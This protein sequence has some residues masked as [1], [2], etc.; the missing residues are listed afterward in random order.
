MY[1]DARHALRQICCIEVTLVEH[2][3]T[4]RS[5]ANAKVERKIGP[6]LACH[7]SGSVQGCFPTCFCP[8]VTHACVI[9]YNIAS[10]GSDGKTPSHRTFQIQP[11]AKE[12][13]IPGELFFFRPPPTMVSCTLPKSSGRLSPGVFL[14]YYTPR[15]GEL[16]EQ[17]VVWSARRLRWEIITHLCTKVYLQAQN[18]PD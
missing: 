3:P 15:A 11:K 16:S 14:D 9:N 17:Y 12:V 7:W 13:S 5:E 10:K 1:C 6:A 4:G 8:S 2:P 18:E